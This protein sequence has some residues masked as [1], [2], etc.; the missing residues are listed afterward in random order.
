[1]VALQTLDDGTKL[2]LLKEVWLMHLPGLVRAQIQD[3]QRLSYA[4]LSRLS[5]EIYN[6]V[7]ASSREHLIAQLVKASRRR[8]S[9][10]KGPGSIPGNS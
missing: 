6:N 5:D 4:Q 1:M 9:G 8:I 7:K 2:D 10:Q 3:A